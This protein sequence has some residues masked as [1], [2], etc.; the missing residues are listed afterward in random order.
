MRYLCA[1]CDG[2]DDWRAD[3]DGSA[4]T[5][6]GDRAWPRP[7]CAGRSGRR[8]DCHG[9]EC[10][11]RLHPR[12]TDVQRRQLPAGEP[13]AGDAR[14]DDLGTRLCRR[15]PA[16]AAARSR[17]DAGR[18]RRPGRG[19]RAGNAR[20]VGGNHRRGHVAI[21]RRC[22]HPFHGHRSAAAQRPQLPRTG[23]AGA[24]QC[25]RTQLRP[26]EV[27]LGRHLFGGAARSRRQHHHRR[28]RQ[29]RRCRRR[30]AAERHP[31]IGAGVP[32]RDAAIHCRI[33]AAPLHR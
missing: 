2:D 10:G 32:D 4:W 9:D 7:G 15:H 1:L 19:R 21:G 17:A 12:R 22:R 27:E 6:D 33:R 28:R 23:A 11:Y 20:R 29:Q 18:G 31:G 30:A 13:A 26:H 3:D 14:P 16:R 5:D 24:G 25:A 8:R